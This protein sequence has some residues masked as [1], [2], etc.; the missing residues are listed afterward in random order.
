MFASFFRMA[1]MALGAPRAGVLSMVIKE[2]LVLVTAGLALGLFGALVLMR[3]LGSMIF[4]APAAAAGA[5]LPPLKLLVDTTT[6]DA[7]TY[8]GV[9][10]CLLVVALIACLMPAKRAAS[11]DPMVALRAQ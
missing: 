4:D 7:I 1:S 2:G 10:L 8:I 6:T 5:A 3:V 9:A 11:V